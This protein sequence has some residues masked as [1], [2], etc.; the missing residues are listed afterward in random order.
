MELGSNF[1][2]TDTDRYGQSHKYR[3]AH[4]ISPGV[5]SILPDPN[6]V[7]EGR[8]LFYDTSGTTN[9]PVGG[10]SESYSNG[11]VCPRYTIT[12]IIKPG[13]T[14]TDIKINNISVNVYNGFYIESDIWNTWTTN[15][16]KLDEWWDEIHQEL[17]NA[18]Y[19]YPGN[20]LKY[21][22][23]INDFNE[24]IEINS[25]KYVSLK[26]SDPQDIT[27]WKPTPATWEGTVIVR[28][29]NSAPLHR[30]DGEKVVRTT[31][32]DK[33]KTKAYKDEDIKANKVYYYGFFPYYT[34]ISDPD[35]PIRFYTF[36]KTIRVETG[37]ITYW[38]GDEIDILWSGSNNKLTVQIQN[39]HIVFRIYIGDNIIYTFNSIVGNDTT[40]ISKINV[41]FLID[42]NSQKAKPSFIYKDT[43]NDVEYKYNQEEPTDSEMQDI[44]T[45]LQPGIQPQPEPG[46]DGSE[47]DIVWSG[48][49]NKLTVQIDNN[50]ILFKMYTSNSEIYSFTSSVGN[51]KDDIDKINVGFIKDDNN[52]IA[53]PSLIYNNNGTYSYNQET[54]TDAEMQDIYT[55]LSAGTNS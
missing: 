15:L 33:Y 14:T 46:W 44:Y 10:S 50:T 23:D 5:W 37:V 55:W 24:N 28:K 27:D 53:K 45:W 22:G 25:K 12:P 29:E 17:Y 1:E 41:G 49:N 43:D 4:Y 18:V 9:Y 32:R 11:P 48:N 34:K 36:T 42:E 20:W 31:T 3:I 7:H 13:D 26:W 16:Q 52:Q 2:V 8:V 40:D 19:M 35:H 51:T 47:I 6:H 39:E 21:N 54:P 38:N 30:W